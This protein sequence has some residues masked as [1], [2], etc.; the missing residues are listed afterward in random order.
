M[1]VT[2]SDRQGGTGGGDRQ[3]VAV[4][5]APGLGRRA[6]GRGYHLSLRMSGSSWLCQRSRICVARARQSAAVEVRQLLGRD[7]LAGAAVKVGGDDGPGL[8]A[9]ALDEADH[10]RVLL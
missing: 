8:E 9:I 3:L 2:D 10:E 4:L 1:G 6:V 5:W 7:L